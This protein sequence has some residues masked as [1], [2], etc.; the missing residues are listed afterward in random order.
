MILN[1]K[2]KWVE[3][4]Q[5]ESEAIKSS[6]MYLIPF[7]NDT[8]KIIVVD[9]DGSK[10]ILEAQGEK[11]DKGDKGDPGEQGEKGDTGEKG[12]IGEISA[13]TFDVN[14]NMHLIMQLETNTS[15]NFNLDSNGHLILVN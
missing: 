13:I 4:V 15:L 3:I 7:E 8:F 6:S 2:F 11:G 5:N 1:K 9:D 12:D 14:E 10:R